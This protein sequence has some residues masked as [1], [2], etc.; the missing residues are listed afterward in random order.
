MK[1]FEEATKIV[2]KLCGKLDNTFDNRFCRCDDIMQS[3]FLMNV[4]VEQVKGT[5]ESVMMNDPIKSIGIMSKVLEIG[6]AIGTL[7]ERREL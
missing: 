5:M 4:I 2:E 7:M 1:T 3:E 6:I